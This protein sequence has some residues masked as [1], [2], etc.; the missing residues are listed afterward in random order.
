MKLDYATLI[1]PYSFYIPNIGHIKSPTLREIW[2]PDITYQKYSAF[3]SIFLITPL[4]YCESINKAKLEWYTSLSYKDRL[5]VSMMDFI[6]DDITLQKNYCIAFTFFL[7]ENV[8][9]DE[10]RS[11]FI[12][13]FENKDK[14]NIVPVGVIHSGIFSE[15]CDIIL[16]RCGINRNDIDI[17]I[18]N[19]KSKKA[20]Q[21]ALKL[22]AGRKSSQKNDKDTELPKLITAISAKSNSL[23]YTNIWDLT[24]YQLQEQFK[25]ECSNVYFDIQKMSVAAYGN[26]KKTFKGTEWYKHDN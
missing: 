1:S 12:T 6:R 14:S 16:Q 20:I 11:V 5:K 19:A 18:S 17:D 2:H 15:L 25:Y 21:T 7:E 3:L 24:V 8:V 26:E 22:Q 10:S 23:N 9:W 4:S 13:Y